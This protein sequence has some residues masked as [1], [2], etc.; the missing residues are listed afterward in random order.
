[1]KKI[2]I[3]LFLAAVT[4][5]SSAQDLKKDEFSLSIGYLFAGELYVWEP[6]RYYS[7]GES[8]LL[9]LDYAHY[10]EAMAKRF[11]VG[12]YVSTGSPYY[13]AYGNESMVEVGILLRGRFS[14]GEK[15]MIKPGAYVGYRSYGSDAGQGLG[16]NADITVQY[17]LEKV[18]PFFQFGFLA[19][20]DGGTPG[21]ITRTFSPTLQ[22]SIGI[23]F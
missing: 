22:T 16:V 6:N 3:L 14:V 11:G 18:K 20:P 12:L 15:V 10:F 7:F 1:M 19:Q 2:L 13:G 8:Y 5:A 17:Q 23:A 21:V 4:S 9:K